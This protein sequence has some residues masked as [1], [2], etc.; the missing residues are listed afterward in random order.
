MVI[1]LRGWKYEERLEALGLTTLDMKTAKR[2]PNPN[3]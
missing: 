3:S 1:E 2:G